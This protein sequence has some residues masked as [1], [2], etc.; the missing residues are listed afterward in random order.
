MY[1]ESLK[2]TTVKVDSPYLYVPSPD[3]N[4]K[5]LHYIFITPLRINNIESK[6]YQNKSTKL[7]YFGARYLYFSHVIYDHFQERSSR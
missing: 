2:G 3:H 5:Y 6:W 1:R 7:T 4:Q